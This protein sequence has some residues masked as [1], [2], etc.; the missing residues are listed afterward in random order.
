MSVLRL[1]V[2]VRAFMDD[3]SG[4]SARGGGWGGGVWAG[5]RRGVDGP[6]GD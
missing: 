2:A 5:E 6:G 3:A 4:L 1:M